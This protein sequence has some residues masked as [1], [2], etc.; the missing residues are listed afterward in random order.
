MPAT[1]RVGLIGVGRWG[2]VYIQTLLSMNKRCRITHLGTGNPQHAGLLPY[3]VEVMT[4]WH[5]LISSDCDAVIIATP[6]RTHAEILEACLEAGKPC[7]VEKPLCLDV[8]TAERIHRRVEEANVPVLVD[9]TYLFNSAY[10]ALKHTIREQNEQ[11]RFLLSE[12]VQLGPFRTHTP[13]LWDWGPHDL[14]LCLDLVGEV[15]ISVSALAGPLDPRGD[16]EL[17]SIRLEFPGGTCAWIQVGRLAPHKRRT[18]SAFTDSHLYVWD[19]TAAEPLMV[20]SAEFSEREIGGIPEGLEQH[21]IPVARHQ[22]PMTNLLTYFLD[23]LTGGDRRYFG[24]HLAVE[25]IHLLAH[26]DTLIKQ[27]GAPS[28]P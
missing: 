5:K 2:K 13:T 1:L 21:P 10:R 20:S 25:V 6:P 18:L 11:V 4:D 8:E 24:T 26:C 17:L 16:P 7:I 22:P 28:P 12:G 23:G 27:A 9:H 3:P 15:P 19:D 14:S